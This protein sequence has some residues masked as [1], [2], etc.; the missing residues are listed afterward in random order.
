MIDWQKIDTVMLDMDGTLLDL[1]FDN[2]FWLHYVPQHYATKHQLP[3]LEANHILRNRFA[4]ESGTLNWYCVEYWSEQL[5]LDIASLKQDISHLITIRPFVIEFLTE[6]AD[7]PQQIILVTNAH[8]K[9][10]NIKLATTGIS[11]W[12]NEIIV[13]HDFHAPKE[14]QEFWQQL[15]LLHPF[16]TERTLLI[17]DTESVLESAQNYGIKNLITLLQPDSKQTKKTKSKFPCIHHFDE[18]MPSSTQ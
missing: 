5:H 6:L 16:N 8:R 17:D 14:K 13:S 1:H 11:K 10:L 15:Y 7:Q 3:I 9:S 12:F 4:A 2:Y 18:I